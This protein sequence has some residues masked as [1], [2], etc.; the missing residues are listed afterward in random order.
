M[1]ARVRGGFRKVSGTVSVGNGAGDSWVDVTVDTASVDTGQPLRDA[2]L[3]S[4]DFLDTDRHPRMRFQSTELQICGSTSAKVTGDLTLKGVTRPVTLDLKFLGKTTDERG[5]P[6][7]A[8]EARASIDREE[9]G[10]LWNRTLDAGG[11]LVGRQIELQIE[12]QA[13]AA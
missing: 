3:R 2:H 13:V 11:V 10:L 12:A 5:V 4:A 1:I 7:L 6:K 9:F 8:F